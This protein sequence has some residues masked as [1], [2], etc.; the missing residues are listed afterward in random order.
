MS[1]RVFPPIRRTRV[2][3]PEEGNHLGYS[4]IFVFVAVHIVGDSV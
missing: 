1:D 4:N 2:G 3:L